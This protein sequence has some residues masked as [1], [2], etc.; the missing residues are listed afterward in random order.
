MQNTK[1]NWD[2]VKSRVNTLQESFNL[3]TILPEEKRSILKARAQ[4]LSVE[5]NDE[6]DE[7]ECIEIVVF[8]LATET[9]GI[10]SKFI[11]EVYPLRDFTVLPGTPSFVLGIV[12]CADKLFR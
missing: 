5:K 9:Y 2:E 7:K 4:A 8:G 10:E 1:I 3:K 12:T 11:R 6:T